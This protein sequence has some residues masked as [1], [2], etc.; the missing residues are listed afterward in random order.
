[1]ILPIETAPQQAFPPVDT[2]VPPTT[3]QEVVILPIETAPQEAKAPITTG[4]CVSGPLGRVR[5][6][7]VYAQT[8]IAAGA[9]R[10]PCTGNTGATPRGSYTATTGDCV[11]GPLGRVRA[12]SAYAQTLIAAGAQRVPCTTASTSTRGSYTPYKRPATQNTYQAPSS[13]GDCVSGP[14]GRVRAGSVYAQTLIAAGAQRVPCTGA[15]GGST[16][17]RGSYTPKAT[18]PYKAAPGG[19]STQCVSGPLGRVRANSLYARGLLASGAQLVPCTGATGAA[20][21]P[22]AAGTQ[23]D[24]V[25]GR[26]AFSGSIYAAALQSRGRLVDCTSRAMGDDG[27]AST[28]PASTQMPAWAVALAVIGT[29]LLVFLVVVM[30][31]MYTLLRK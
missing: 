26:R 31:Q 16:T 29:I 20:P 18:N 3:P 5:A 28:M 15:T 10:V 9:Q 2:Q 27:S 19:D 22:T 24:S 8:L 7:S 17:P 4:D 21:R 13:T 1:V 6:G 30:V 12:G 25:T 23:C 11:S 14:L